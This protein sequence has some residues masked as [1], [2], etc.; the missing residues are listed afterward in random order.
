LWKTTQAP[1][2]FANNLGAGIETLNPLPYAAGMVDKSASDSNNQFS[3]L[4]SSLGNFQGALGN[5]SSVQGSH[6]HA[7]ANLFGRVPSSSANISTDAFTRAASLMNSGQYDRSAAP[8]APLSNLYQ[9]TAFARTPSGA[10]SMSML[11]FGLFQGQQSGGVL[12]K[13]NDGMG[14]LVQMAMPQ[15]SM[16]SDMPWQRPATDNFARRTSSSGGND[17]AT[18]FAAQMGLEGVGQSLMPGMGQWDASVLGAAGNVPMD[19]MYPG[20]FMYPYPTVPQS[21]GLQHFGFSHDGKMG[22]IPA[23]NYGPHVMHMPQV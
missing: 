16:R 11:P 8:Q 22:M 14:N 19:G 6:A 13:G 20:M 9:Q 4:T 5:F 2:E 12:G 1:P 3:R 21:V 17:G 18:M 23:G 7:N 15:A 10:Q